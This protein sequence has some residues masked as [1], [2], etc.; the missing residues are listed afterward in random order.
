MQMNNNPILVPA[1]VVLTVAEDEEVIVTSSKRTKKIIPPFRMIGTGM[2]NKHYE[3][4]PLVQTLLEL[5]RPE[6]NFLK[7]LL[8]VYDNEAGFGDIDMG[9][10]TQADRN[11]SSKAYKLL[12]ERNLII[13]V[14]QGRYMINPF[15]FIPSDQS[16][17]EKQFNTWFL[18]G[19]K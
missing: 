14:K 11:T 8:E 6:Q 12:R 4:Y 13:R 7:S 1:Q 3:S 18:L 5:S 10:Y 19:G 2:V 17:R 15:A 9:E 16:V